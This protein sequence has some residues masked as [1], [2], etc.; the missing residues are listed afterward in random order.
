MMNIPLTEILAKMPV[1][2]LEQTLKDFLVPLTELLPEKRL[3][4][5]APEAVRGILSQETPVI[6]AMAQ[7]TPRQERSRYAGAKRIYRFVWNE[8]FHHHQLFKGIY[9]IA[10]RAVTEE[11][12]E[13]LVVALDPVNFEKPYTKTLEGVRTSATR[14]TVTDGGQNVYVFNESGKIIA[15]ADPQGR[16]WNY[17]YNANGNLDKVS[18]NNGASYLAFDY[19]AQ[20]RIISVS[21]HSGRRVSFQYDSAGDLSAATDVL[22]QTWT[23]RYDS[24]HR[25]TQVTAP[26]QTVVERTEYDSQGRAVRQ[27]DG[28]GN[29]VVEL[30]FNADGSTTITDALGHRQ[31]HTYDA[32]RTLVGKTDG[33]GAESVT[34]YGYN[35]QPTQITNAAGA[36]LSMTWSADGVNLLEKT[37]PLGHTTH[38]TY[39]ALNNLT[40]T[41]DPLGNTWTYTYDP[42]GNLIRAQEN[43][44]KPLPPTATPAVC[45]FPDAFRHG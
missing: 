5:V 39:D 20:G 30:T 17:T 31:T 1:E 2:E 42:A 18:A 6:A 10:R 16:S 27:Y 25:L 12:P 44:S 35:F 40:S 9:R 13:Y 43:V 19:D 41:T 28:E 22:G 36:P 37:D 21:D 45:L 26:D 11:N 8:R 33:L 32:R 29:P 34:T 23:Y 38:N 7:S 4:R 15:F 24:A 3:R 14:Y